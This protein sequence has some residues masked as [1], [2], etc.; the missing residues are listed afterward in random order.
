MRASARGL[1]PLD[2][3]HLSQVFGSRPSARQRGVIKA[4]QPSEA[5]PL[6]GLRRSLA[7]VRLAMRAVGAT[8][9][10]LVFLVGPVRAQAGASTGLMGRV[11]DSSGAAVPGVAVTLTHVETGSER[12]VTTN[13][14][15]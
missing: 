15:G 13:T 9:L 14:Y 11:T 2:S 3:E 8:A 10:L 7:R 1:D 6:D 4:M 12:T 5:E